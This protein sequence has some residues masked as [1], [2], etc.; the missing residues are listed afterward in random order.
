M[1]PDYLKGRAMKLAKIVFWI[2]AIW[3]FLMIT[4]LFFI[5]DMIGK[6]DPPPITHPGF[7]Y[8][9]GTVTLAWQV[10][11]VMIARDPIRLRPMMI[12]SML[13]K[14]LYVIAAVVLFMQAR[15]KAPDM[16]FVAAD[17]I[18]GVLFVIAYVKTKATAGRTASAL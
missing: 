10:A 15:L 8:G 11:F 3:G 1:I 6:N 2:A 7:Y 5:F 4:P 9:F 17:A 12:P 14:L 18:L 13:E 16:I